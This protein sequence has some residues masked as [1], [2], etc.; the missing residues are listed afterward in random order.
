MPNFS[1]FTISR[2]L[3]TAALT[4]GREILSLSARTVSGIPRP[5]AASK[6]K[7]LRALTAFLCFPGPAIAGSGT[8]VNS[9]THCASCSNPIHLE[10]NTYFPCSLSLAINSTCSTKSPSPNVRSSLF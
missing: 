6:H 5:F 8:V 7:M 10:A 2:P 1:R 9:V 4:V 3:C